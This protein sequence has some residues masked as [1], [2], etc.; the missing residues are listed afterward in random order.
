M[1]NPYTDEFREDLLEQFIEELA[2]KHPDKTT[3]ELT[4]LAIPMVL[5]QI[6]DSYRKNHFN[7]P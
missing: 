2:V 5:G 7:E 3:E 6:E 4:T 1:S